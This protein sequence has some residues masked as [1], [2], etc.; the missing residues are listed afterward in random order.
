M[1]SFR[2]NAATLKNLR[3]GLTRQLAKDL[4]RHNVFTPTSHPKLQCV[5]LK[6]CTSIHSNRTMAYPEV[7]QL[8]ESIAP[9][10]AA[11]EVKFWRFIPSPPLVLSLFGKLTNLQVLALPIL[12]LSVWDA[13]SLF[14]SLPLL[15]DFHADA[16]TLD[17]L[18]NGVIQS[19]LVA[20]VLANYSTMALRFRC[21]HMW[22]GYDNNIKNWAIP[23]VLLA[24]ACPNFDFVDVT[25]ST[26]DLLSAALE[27]VMSMNVFKKYALRLRRLLPCGLE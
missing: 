16:P 11:R 27:R 21:W 25:P 3:L 7:L 14:K 8:I 18:P 26:R 17:P 6:L 22:F 9:N 2:G 15:T 1:A 23:F 12:R 5:S 10:A 24:L 19:K 13:M 4:L 20:H